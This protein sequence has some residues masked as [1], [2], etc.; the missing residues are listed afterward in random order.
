[1]RVLAFDRRCLGKLRS[2]IGVRPE[3][4]EEGFGQGLVVGSGVWVRQDDVRSA[5]F[6]VRA[7]QGD[8]LLGGKAESYE[9]G[10]IIDIDLHR[11]A[12]RI[13]RLLERQREVQR[14]NALVVIDAIIDTWAEGWDSF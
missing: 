12:V 6:V 13:D 10:G 1:M 11:L 4:A 5:A 8:R 2:E 9:E 14:E 3:L 7:G